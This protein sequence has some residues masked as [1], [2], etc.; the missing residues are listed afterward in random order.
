M[1]RVKVGL[2]IQW[3]AQDDERRTVIRG[4]NV[5]ENRGERRISTQVGEGQV[6][7]SQMTM[8]EKTKKKRAGTTNVTGSPHQKKRFLGGKR[9][10]RQQL[11]YNWLGKHV[12]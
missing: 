6:S 7:G 11:K 5:V 4:R 9:R 3:P 2:M 1:Q 12:R 10:D 8:E